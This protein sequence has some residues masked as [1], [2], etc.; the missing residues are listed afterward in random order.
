MM[1]CKLLTVANYNYCALFCF[2]LRATWFWKMN[3]CTKPCSS[4]QI[5]K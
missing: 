3:D 5:A 4:V 2:N 1:T